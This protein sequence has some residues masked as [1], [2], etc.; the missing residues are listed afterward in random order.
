M[1]GLLINDDNLLIVSCEN[2]TINAIKLSKDDLELNIVG[3]IATLEKVNI[4][5]T[6]K[7]DVF[8]CG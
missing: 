3:K 5:K 2:K 8:F 7:P 6:L 1:C 4:M